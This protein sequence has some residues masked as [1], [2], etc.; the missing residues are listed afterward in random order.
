MENF[1]DM[2][3]KLRDSSGEMKPNLHILNEIV[4]VEEQVRYFKFSK[5]IQNNN[6]KDKFDRNYLIARL[7]TPEVNVEDKRYYLTVLASLT[8]VAAYRAIE[9]YHRNPLEKELQN[10][11][12]M[13]L[14]E[15]RILLDTELSGEKQFYVS[16]GLGGKDNKLRFF[17]VIASASRNEFTVFQKEIL[18]RELQ[19]AFDRDKIEIESLEI[20]PDYIRL[21]LL[22]DLNH[23]VNLSIENAIKECNELGDFVDEKFLVTNLKQ[24]NDD[25]ISKLLRKEEQPS[26][27]E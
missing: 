25:E 12:A 20:K 23:Q 7:F 8:D 11:S 10:W 1:D 3:S 22:C 14:I 15:S 18:I 17:A 9:A 26:E 4:P 27:Q 16:T 5:Y 19:F 2:L 21:L 6:D 13:A 24:L